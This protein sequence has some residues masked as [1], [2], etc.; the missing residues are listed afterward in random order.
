MWNASFVSVDP[1]IPGSA[2]FVLFDRPHDH[3]VIVNGI[4]ERFSPTMTLVARGLSSHLLVD[5]TDREIE[6]PEG[7]GLLDHLL[8]TA[9]AGG[10]IYLVRDG[11]RV[12]A[13]VPADVAES[14]G[15]DGAGDGADAVERAADLVAEADLSNGPVPQ[16]KVDEVD[17]E[18]R[19]EL[20]R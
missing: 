17:R 4:G 16:D 14:L 10:T 11:V 6:V 15:L 9:E 18:W 7:S 19:A 8:A 20:R 5:M 13:V 1:P 12:A 3:G 2:P